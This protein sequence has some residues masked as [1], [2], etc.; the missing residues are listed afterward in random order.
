MRSS[1]SSS[2]LTR[3]TSQKRRIA[4]SVWRCFCSHA[5]IVTFSPA[6]AVERSAGRP[7]LRAMASSAWAMARLS[8]QPSNGNSSER[9]RHVQ[10][11]RQRRRLDRAAPPIRVRQT[12]TGQKT[13]FVR[14]ADA[15]IEIL[16]IGAAAQRDVLA[17]VHVLAAGQHV[18]RGAAAQMGPLFEQTHAEA[19]FS[20]RDGR[21]KSR[22]AAADHDHALRGHYVGSTSPAARAT[23][24]PF[25]QECSAAHV[26]RKHHSRALRCGAAG[27][28]K[29]APAPRARRARRRA[30]AGSVPRLRD[31][32]S[33]R[34][35]P[36]MRS[37][38]A[39]L[40]RQR[41]RAQESS[42]RT[43]N[44]ARSSSGR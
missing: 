6:T 5:S 42:G 9:R 12:A 3:M 32:N 2:A 43:P 38:L 1:S 19:G 22:Q 44:C 28:C 18:G 33:R 16:E 15:A 39:E 34:A 20:Q 14:S 21:G 25:F 11:R 29:S 41:R 8:A 37:R 26:R 13:E 27:C 31:K 35:L 24:S 10:R 7:P 40:R 17:I 36:R 23:G 4:R 30:R